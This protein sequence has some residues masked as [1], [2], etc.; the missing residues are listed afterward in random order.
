MIEWKGA[1]ENVYGDRN[2]LY[3]DL[4]SDQDKICTFYPMLIIHQENLAII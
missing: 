1:E 3:L 4:M 2:V